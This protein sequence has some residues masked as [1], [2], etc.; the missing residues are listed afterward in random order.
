MSEDKSMITRRQLLEK[1]ASA[2]ATTALAMIAPTL[3]ELAG[4]TPGAHIQGESLLPLLKGETKRWRNSFLIEHISEE[5][6]MPWLI[7]M[8]YKAVRMDNYKY[9][10]WLHYDGGDELYDLKADPYERNN[11]INHPEYEQILG[12]AQQELERLVVEAH[13]LTH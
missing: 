9:I 5:N 10:H 13:R 11:L 12:A 1:C 6:T 4:L 8:G 3:I 2:R 7:N